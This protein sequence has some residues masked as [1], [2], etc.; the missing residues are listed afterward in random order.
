VLLALGSAW[1]PAD[2]RAADVMPAKASTS[3]SKPLPCTNPRDFFTTDC[4]LSWYGITI[5]GTIDAGFG[6]QSSDAPW[7]PRSAVGASYPIQKQDCNSVRRYAGDATCRRS[8]PG[9]P[10]YHGAG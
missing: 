2:V 8:L 9:G 10:E 4:Q 6:W 7:D 3:P 5:F 1:V